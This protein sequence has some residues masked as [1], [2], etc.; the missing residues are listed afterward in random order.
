[1]PGEEKLAQSS[2]HVLRC[3]CCFF[4]EGSC[5]ASQEQN[6]TFAYRAAVSLRASP[7]W[8]WKHRTCSGRKETTEMLG[9]DY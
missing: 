2:G 6:Y 5:L 9:D 7:P 3:C 4:K 8:V 1:M